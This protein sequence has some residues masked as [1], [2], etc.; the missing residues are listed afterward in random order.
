[1]IDFKK[2]INEILPYDRAKYI[3]Y[4]G[5]SQNETNAWFGVSFQLNSSEQGLNSKDFVKLYK[6]LFQGLIG[7]F[8]N[9][10]GTKP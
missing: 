10:S 6:P 9:G 7:E 3:E 1:M 2:R 5:D 8:D 4:L